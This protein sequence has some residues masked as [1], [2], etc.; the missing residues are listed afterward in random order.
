MQEKLLEFIKQLRLGGVKVSLVE[1]FDCFQAL[2]IMPWDK[3]S[4]YNTLLA[5]L[6]KEAEHF[7][8]FDK[9]F[10]YYFK[11]DSFFHQQN[12]LDQFTKGSLVSYAPTS[13]NEVCCEGTG[14]SGGGGSGQGRGSIPLKQFIET[15][16][17]GSKEEFENLI[18]EGISRVGEITQQNMVEREDVIRRIKVALQ[19][20]MGEYELTKV[21]K[22]SNEIEKIAVQEKLKLLEELLEEKLDQFFLARYKEVALKEILKRSN[23]QELAF[24]DL[25]QNQISEIKKKVT[26][27]AHR[28]ATRVSRRESRGK[29]G[30]INLQ[31]TIRKSMVTGG[32]PLYPVF[33]QRQ[34][35]RPEFVI[36]C[37]LSGSVRLFSEFMLQLTYSIQNRFIHVRSFAF[38]DTIQEITQYFQK[39]DITEAIRKIYY[40]GKFS[41]TGFSHYGESLLA[42][43]AQYLNI[44]SRK[45]TVLIIGDARNNY[46]KPHSDQLKKLQELAYRIFWLNPAPVEKWNSED[47]I[48]ETYR[49][50]CRKVFECGNLSQLER[51][52]KQLF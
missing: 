41:K 31:G 39:Q 45:T 47:S 11:E 9:L 50:F 13:T 46:Q 20:K 12:N 44:I 4:F 18:L 32:V 43:N 25:S 2:K 49:P 10:Q 16:Q 14:G 15:V 6:V 26:Q 3:K 48:I 8:L 24:F 28:L 29:K 7:R 40:D 37:D 33:R 36:L 38:V 34:P 35:S 1:T 17:L 42:F 21:L 30:K 52:V 19:W 22:D 23:L 27:L 5:T 51:V